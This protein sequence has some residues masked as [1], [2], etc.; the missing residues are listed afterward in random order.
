MLI[1]ISYKGDMGVLYAI[2]TSKIGPDTPEKIDLT[3][4]SN[5]IIFF[6]IIL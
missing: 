2:E 3:D 6:E 5:Y 4:E 1:Y